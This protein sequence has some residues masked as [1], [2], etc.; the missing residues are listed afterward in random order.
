[1][2]NP[3]AWG[4]GCD[5][6]W[7]TK[8]LVIPWN[9][10]LFRAAPAP[11]GHAQPRLLFVPHALH[12]TLA[13]ATG[14][15]CSSGAFTVP[16]NSHSH[17]SPCCLPLPRGTMSFPTPSGKA[18]TPRYEPSPANVEE[19]SQT[20]RYKWLFVVRKKIP[21]PY[22]LLPKVKKEMAV[23]FSIREYSF[24]MEAAHFSS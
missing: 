11:C 22:H 23:Y 9:E 13:M 17:P 4:K 21:K 10:G 15:S 5:R 2:L 1:M 24:P 16:Q 18:L 8:E 7:F 6:R 12:V 19:Q 14:S 3:C 20:S